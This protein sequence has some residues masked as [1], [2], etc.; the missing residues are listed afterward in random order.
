VPKFNFRDASDV[1][2]RIRQRKRGYTHRAPSI[3]WRIEQ[4]IGEVWR[5]RAV[6]PTR[7]QAQERMTRLWAR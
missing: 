3:R 1:E 6:A 5:L 7:K 4:R 2:W